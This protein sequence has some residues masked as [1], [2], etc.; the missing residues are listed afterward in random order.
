MDDSTNAFNFDPFASGYGFDL[1]ADLTAA[2]QVS[3]APPLGMLLVEQG[4]LTEEQL[5]G[6]LQTQY[7]QQ[8]PLV[9]LLL[10]SGMATQEQVLAAL[11]IRPTYG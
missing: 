5:S 2:P 4:V 7:E 9:Q 3:N 1:P 10:E 6:L 11:R 8:V